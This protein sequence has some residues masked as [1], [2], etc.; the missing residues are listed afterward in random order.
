MVRE[1]IREKLIE[2]IGIKRLEH[3]YRVMDTAIKLARVYNAD[4]EKARIAGIYHDCAKF[5]DRAKLLKK[6]LDF[7]I[8][9]NV[10]EIKNIETLH[11][12]VGAFMAKYEY[13]IEDEEILNAIEFHT[14]ARLNMTLLD[15]IIYMADYIE[16]KRNFEGLEEIRELAFE[17]IDLAYRMALDH[18]IKFVVD[19]G[20]VLDIITVEARNQMVEILSN[21][22]DE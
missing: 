8:I 4:E 19:S 9:Q 7:A 5:Q 10:S 6:A 17:N 18:T 11:G 21:E 15:K 1:E 13:K 22:E 2:D 20:K 16:P 14:T 12:K 3:S